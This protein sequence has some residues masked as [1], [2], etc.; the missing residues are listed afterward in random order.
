MRSRLLKLSAGIIVLLMLIAALHVLAQPAPGGRPPGQG[1][2]FG[3]G[4]MGMGM[5]MMPGWPPAPTPVM[6]VADGIL[7][8]ACDGKLTAYDAK[9][10]EV[11]GEAIYWQREAPPQR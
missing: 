2:G 10:L 4:G 5:G 7:Y 9:T 8:L 11:L 1:Q 6:T 3:G